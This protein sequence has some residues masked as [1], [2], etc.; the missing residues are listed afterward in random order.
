MQWEDRCIQEYLD[1]GGHVRHASWLPG[2]YIRRIRLARVT[3]DF[4][5]RPILRGRLA[6]GAFKVD[7]KTERVPFGSHFSTKTRGEGWERIEDVDVF[8]DLAS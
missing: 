3:R 4:L 8:A 2:F 6:L 1:A 7:E 5:Y